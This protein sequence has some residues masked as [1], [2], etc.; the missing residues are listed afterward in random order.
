MS[1][2]LPIKD[3]T[4][5]LRINDCIKIITQASWDLKV[6][7]T[8]YQVASLTPEQYEEYVGCVEDIVVDFSQA[9]AKLTILLN[10]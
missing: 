6:I 5:A 7:S 4:K 10:R 8:Q 1:T 9:V 2:H 3:L